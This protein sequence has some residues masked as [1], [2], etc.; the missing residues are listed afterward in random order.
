VKHIFIGIDGTSNAAFYDPFMSNVFRFDS[1]LSHR[2]M[3]G[4]DQVFIYL[5]GV[6]P[7][8]KRLL[9]RKVGRSDV[10]GRAFGRGIDELVLQAYINLVSNY[11]SNDKSPDKI[12]I[13]GFSRG[14]VAARALTGLIS[15]SGL[16]RSDR[17]IHIQEAWRY[18][19]E[20]ENRY[21]DLR[22]S[23]THKKTAVE[24]LGLW[25]AVYGRGVRRAFRKNPFN[26][27]RLRSYSLDSLVDHAVHLISIDDTRRNFRPIFWETISRSKQVMEQIWM[28]GV[29]SDIGGGYSKSFFSTLS[30]LTMIDKLKEH[31]P[32]I[33]FDDGYINDQL[34]KQLDHHDIAINDE[35]ESYV[36]WTDWWATRKL[37]D[38][39]RRAGG[40]TVHPVVD[41]LTGKKI[42]IRGKE[43]VYSPSAVM[44]SGR[45]RI[46]ETEFPHRSLHRH[47][48]H[49]ILDR[50]VAAL[51]SR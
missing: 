9:S 29:H 20:E 39:L 15:H 21:A 26:L 50:K 42:N 14:A 30:L 40:H 10:L 32:K 34:M 1:A 5:N 47:Q 43:S 19:L 31:C 18:F 4:N 51:K 12:Y 11:E 16:L 24:F 3:E 2:D 37:S 44:S 13:L 25:D 22:F 8:R 7:P 35:W 38:E 28:P 48:I 41:R 17:S 45:K 36:P 27:F 49:S 46:A 23:E 6:A 33:R